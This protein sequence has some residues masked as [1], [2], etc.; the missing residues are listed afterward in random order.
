MTHKETLIA[1]AQKLLQK[2]Q[3]DK[4]IKGYQ[5]AVALDPGDI[6]VRQRLAELLVRANRFEE[7]RTEFEAV[8]KNLSA[9]GFY[10]KAIAVYKQIE[11]LF[12]DDISTVLTLADLNQR[13]GLLPNALAEYKRAFDHYEAAKNPAEGA[14]VL[15][16]MQKA[17]PQNVNIRL[18]H[19][20]VLYQAGDRDAS[21]QAFSTLAG[22][23]IDRKDSTAFARLAVKMG[24]MFEDQDGFTA[25]II[26]EKITSGGAEQAV[27]IL[28]SLLKEAPQDITC[29]RLVI[30]ACHSL[31]QWERLKMA[32]RHLIQ[33]YPSDIMPREHLIRCLLRENST[34]E[35]S[36]LLYEYEPLFRDAGALRIL[37]ELYLELD[38][39]AP[40]DTEILSAIIRDCEAAEAAAMVD[41]G[42]KPGTPPD[43]PAVS[44]AAS[45][46]AEAVDEEDEVFPALPVWD[47]QP[48]AE[49]EKT[50]E[51]PL[52]EV[53]SASAVSDTPVTVSIMADS[54][55]VVRAL[56]DD[57]FEIEVDLDDGLEQDVADSRT[58]TG[59]DWFETVSGIFET[60]RTDAGA[61]KF[62]GEL[63]SADYQS[64]FDLGLAFREMG[65]FDD[66]LAE[67]RQAAVEPSQRIRCLAMQAACLREKGESP[68]AEN[69]LRT[70]LVSSELTP[71]EAATVKYELA[72]TL[73]VLGNSDEAAR[74]FEEVDQLCPGFR[75]VA[76]LS[77]D[78]AGME[79]SHSLDFSD[80]D[81]LEFDLKR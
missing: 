48:A 50:D 20:E 45:A 4:A 65:L 23:L 78:T 44:A 13:H 70:L 58:H 1:D 18:K 35:A 64:H 19:A 69:A 59:E 53:A 30:E 38:A 62:G 2:G 74:L 8:G 49:E 21:L 77:K 9:N 56:E 11:R 33:L 10:L 25:R 6:R 16:L 54:G 40:V 12:P 72:L 55:D 51:I 34:D 76:S 5:E 42:S 79:L 57:P 26:K 22:L 15:A 60:I 68:V 63:E 3:M 39:Q 28:Q 17:D 46:C 27:Q 14:K 47:D 52:E 81:L 43:L 73:Q 29:W 75:D 61:V 67:F 80:D 66:A 32:C 71:Q 36:R 37:K 41:P 31:E 24:Q 7:A